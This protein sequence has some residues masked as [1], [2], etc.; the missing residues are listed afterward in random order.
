VSR[1]EAWAAA[2]GHESLY[3]FTERGSE[4]AQLYQRLGWQIIRHDQFENLAVTVMRKS[5]P[6]WLDRHADRAGS[7]LDRLQRDVVRDPD[8]RHGAAERRTGRRQ[9]LI[10]LPG[11]LMAVLI[12]I[13]V[14]EAC[15]VTY[16]VRPSGV[17]AIRPGSPPTLIGLPGRRVRVL[18]GVTVPGLEPSTYTVLPFGLITIGTGS[19][20][21]QWRY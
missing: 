15:M 3:L 12:G 18:I 4:A 9:T 14:F 1:C 17:I 7:D 5:L 11:L 8:R 13:T 10:G 6:L 21:A 16:R 20:P 2:L 19:Y